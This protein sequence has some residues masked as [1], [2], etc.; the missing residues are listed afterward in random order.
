MS[1]NLKQYL[2]GKIVCGLKSELKG[3]NNLLI[4]L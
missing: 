1:V 3:K 2:L 4:D